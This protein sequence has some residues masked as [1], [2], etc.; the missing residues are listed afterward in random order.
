MTCA[1]IRRRTLFSLF[2]LV[3]VAL[4]GLLAGCSSVA[5]AGSR[6]TSGR[7]SGRI[8]RGAKTQTASGRYR[9]VES[10]NRDELEILT[11]LYGVLG[12]VVRT[13]QGARLERG[14]DSVEEAPS[15]E[16][17]MERAFGFSLPLE[18]MKAWLNGT[19]AANE[20]FERIDAESFVQRGSRVAVRRRSADGRAAVVALTRAAPEANLVL[21]LTIDEAP[22]AP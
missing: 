2:A 16:E 4:A 19:P 12:R 7:F 17:L 5:P 14:S 9:Y 22:G 1:L 3:P 21:T 18:M 6:V 15:A 20:S 13:P 10:P 11:P 8:T